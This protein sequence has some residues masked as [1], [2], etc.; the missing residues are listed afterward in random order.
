MSDSQSAIAL[1]ANSSTKS[2][3]KHID[4]KYHFIRE[5]IA[6]GHV[7]LVFCPSESMIADALTM[8][9]P[10]EQFELLPEDALEPK[11]TSEVTENASFL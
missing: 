10:R 11:K 6:N 5:A 1:S 3:A 8:Q 9:V 4:I 2:R 7:K